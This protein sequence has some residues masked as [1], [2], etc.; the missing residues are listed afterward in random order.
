MNRAQFI[1]TRDWLLEPADPCIRYLTLRDLLSHEKDDPTL[2]A[3]LI[4]SHASEPIA[5]VLNNMHPDGYW[6]KPGAGYSPKYRSTVWALILLAQLGASINSDPRI[7]QACAYLL[8]HGYAEGGYFTHSGAPGGT[9]DCLQGN[10]CWALLELGCTDPRLTDAFEWMARSQIG[11]GIAA[12]TEKDDY[13]RYY[14]YKSG[15][16]FIC[17][18]NSNLPCAWGATKVMMAFSRLPEDR[19]TD[20]IKRAIDIGVN[21]IFSIEPTSAS[22]PYDNKINGTWWK[23]GF[24]V[25]YNTDLLQVA[26]AM[27]GLGYGGDP[28]LAGLIQLIESKADENG[29]WKLEHDYKDKT[30]GNYGVKGQ[31]NKWVT[32]RALRVLDAVS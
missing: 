19:R 9:F 24:P 31:P 29:K 22:W 27:V 1:T 3:A 17:G 13:P 5:R 20:L 14:A 4:E 21:F 32:L 18:C 11:E 28:R 15:P 25:F 2:I 6:S 23:F 30:W 7:E 16:G 8:E 12:K 26:E 10:L